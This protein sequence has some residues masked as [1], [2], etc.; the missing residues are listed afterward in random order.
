MGTTMQPMMLMSLELLL[1][2]LL[3]PP[4]PPPLMTTTKKVGISL[5]EIQT[6][7]AQ[8]CESEA[9]VTPRTRQ[10]N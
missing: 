6:A 9:A 8:D 2:L 4:P 7:A 5:R 10:V 1:L 3:L